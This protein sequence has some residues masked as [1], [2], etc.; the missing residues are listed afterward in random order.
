MREASDYLVYIV[1]TASRESG[2]VRG[3]SAHL[4]TVWADRRKYDFDPRAVAGW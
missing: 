3:E 4:A 2:V 1:N